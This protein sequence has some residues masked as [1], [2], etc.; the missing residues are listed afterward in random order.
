MN[1]PPVPAGEQSV[2]TNFIRDVLAMDDKTAL[3]VIVQTQVA[4]D[5][6]SRHFLTPDL[7]LVHAELA[8]VFHPPK[9]AV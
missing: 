2:I 5:E 1:P 8:R 3:R 4:L 6:L 7:E 9:P